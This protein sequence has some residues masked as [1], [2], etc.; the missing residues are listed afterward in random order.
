VL[1]AIDYCVHNQELLRRERAEELARIEE[2]EK[3]YPSRKPPHDT[4]E[5][6]LGQV[7]D[8]HQGD[9][10]GEIDPAEY[11]ERRHEFIFHMLD[12]RG[13]LR[14]LIRLFDN[15]ESQDLALAVRFLTGFLY[16]VIPH[17][18]AA[19]RLLLD[20]VPDPFVEA[21]SRPGNRS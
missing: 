8:E 2:H 16:H 10:R 15:P 18:S 12:W 4:L 6:L 3:R 20:H 7:F 21:Q 1:E 13:D 9:L 5:R 14:A 19:G 17:L 11:A